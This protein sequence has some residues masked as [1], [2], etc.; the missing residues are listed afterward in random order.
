[1]GGI[2]QMVANNVAPATVTI[3]APILYLDAVDYVGS[4]TTWDA[5]NGTDATLV[6]TPT[7]TAPAPT[8][9][10]FAPASL[11]EATLPALSSLNNW[12]I[13][14][15]FRV[16]ATLTGQVTAVICDQW[17]L[18]TNLNFSMGTNNAPTDYR[19]RIGF[20]NGAW[21]N[22]AGFAPTLNTW[23]H[24]VGTYDGTT[25]KEYVDGTLTSSASSLGTS[26]SGGVGLRVARRWDE[27]A[28]STNYFPGDVGL[29]R[30]WNSALS[31]AQVQELYDENFSRFSNSV[32]TSN[33]VA[34]WDPDLVASYPGTG[35]T[36]NNLTATSLPG[37]MSNI[38]YTDPYF[39]YNGTSSTVSIADNAVLEPG[40]S[41]FTLEA[42]VYYSVLA[43]STRTF[44]SKTNNGGG[45]ADW[46]YGFRTNGTTGGTY[47]EIGNGTTS[48]I[49]PSFTVS[50]GQWY[51]IVGVWTNVASNSI[52]L[53]VNGAS[54]GSN[55]HSF[56][57][58]KD[59]TNPLYLGS[60]N[61]GEFSQWFNG[62]MGIVR[63]Y[64]AALTAGQVLQ[65]FNANR[66][67][68]GL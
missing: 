65:N 7:F 13:E 27:T 34:Y 43:G 32:V 53:Y 33:L 60:Y 22:T 56:A 3:P 21:R 14:A 68:Y 12:T 45:A 6:N 47:F 4:G 38:T 66:G 37:T 50:T 48:V 11:E 59:S 46:S 15:W 49:S 57:S 18:T 1:M 67:V 51:Q 31:A 63:Y 23:Y 29:T 36:I 35:T 62:Q 26:S 8:Y 24:M 52:A 5:Q 64:S 41:D 39:A 44:V 20:F 10:S 58:V 42:W 16:T 28:T 54:Q 61:G 17:N 30:I 25:M 9:F 40:L 19:M 55:A 2:M